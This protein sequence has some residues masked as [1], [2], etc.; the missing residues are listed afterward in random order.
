MDAADATAQALGSA[1]EVRTEDALTARLRRQL[2]R[3]TIDLRPVTDAEEAALRRGAPLT[4]QRPC[5]SDF[6]SLSD[7]VSSVADRREGRK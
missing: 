1:G 5:T 3:A 6:R 2:E 4:F 7:R